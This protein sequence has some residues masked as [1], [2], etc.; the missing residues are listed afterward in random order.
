MALPGISQVWWNLLDLPQL[1]CVFR[2]KHPTPHPPPPE[3]LTSKITVWEQGAQKIKE[4]QR[5]VKGVGK[6]LVVLSGMQNGSLMVL[7]AIWPINMLYFDKLFFDADIIPSPLS[8][9]LTF[10]NERFL[11]EMHLLM[12]ATNVLLPIH[13]GTFRH[14]VSQTSR[15][16]H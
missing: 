13:Q 9:P 6:S 10:I 8:I 15:W 3:G 7:W 12:V 1:K 16:G 2:Q 4:R 11:G 5:W 14:D